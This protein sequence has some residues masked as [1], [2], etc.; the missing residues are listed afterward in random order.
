MADIFTYGT[1]ID[2]YVDKAVE[3][4]KET[5]P[6]ATRENLRRNYTYAIEESKGRNVFVSYFKWSSGETDREELD[7]DGDK[8]IEKIVNDHRFWIESSNKVAK[9]Y[10]IPLPGGTKIIGW[11]LEEYCFKAHEQGGYSATV[12]AGNREAGGS[13]DFFIPGS[14]LKGTFEDFVKKY[15]DAAPWFF[16]LDDRLLKNATGLKEFLGFEK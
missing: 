14:F 16:M 6:W 8:F 9:V 7:C 4:L 15:N 10:R 1:D 13:R 11:N 12:T 3:K 5:Y 2:V